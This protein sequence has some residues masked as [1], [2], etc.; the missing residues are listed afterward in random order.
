MSDA[1]KRRGDSR[2]SASLLVLAALTLGRALQ[3]NYGMFDERALLWLSA[4]FGLCATGIVWYRVRPIKRLHRFGEL[5]LTS[6]LVGGLLLQLLQLAFAPPALRFLPEQLPPAGFRAA[7]AVVACLVI[8]GATRLPGLKRIWFPLVLLV[9][10]SLGYWILA[11]SPRSPVDVYLFQNDASAALIDGRNPYTVKYP[12]IYGPDTPF[13]GPGLTKDGWLTFGFPYLPFSL[14]LA[15]PGH[16]MAGDFRYANL[17][18]YGLSGVLMGYASSGVV[19]Q[20][21]ACFYLFTP[22][23]FLILE[24]GWTEPQV[25]LLL[26][27]TTFCACRM[28]RAVPL[29]FG[30]FLAVKQY[31]VLAVPIAYLLAR[32]T[33]LELPKLLAVS[34]L[35][36]AA[37]TLPFLLWDPRPFVESVVTLQL[38]QPFRPD[39]LSYPAWIANQGGPVL[40]AGLA[41][42]AAAAALAV[43]LWLLPRTQA[44]A[45]AAMGFVYFAFFA[46][47][48]QA[49][50]NY[51]LFVIGALCCAV[52]ALQVKESKDA[53]ASREQP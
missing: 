45:T 2:L 9:H 28:P 25:V 19:A 7:L 50:A 31:L 4:A 23:V 35:A 16:L 46:F 14:L 29:V 41:F 36:A 20:L 6:I 52:A 13:Y 33:R 27:A 30:L 17:V 11:G 24:G 38:K 8:L 22:L 15:L 3:I 21:A 37:I 39:S 34:L 32:A 47:N 48:K 40:P 53:K 10:A 49:F 42:G 18:A 44:G 1:D 43:A 51:Y 26:S 5:G 12:N